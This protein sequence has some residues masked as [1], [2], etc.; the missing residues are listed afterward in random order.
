MSTSAI[1]HLAN[2]SAAW[3]SLDG[4]AVGACESSQQ[5][6]DFLLSLLSGVQAS[7]LALV[8]AKTTETTEIA[9][10]ESHVRIPEVATNGDEESVELEDEDAGEKL[11]TPISF[12]PQLLPELARTGARVSDVGLNSVEDRPAANEDSNIRESGNM[13]AAQFPEQRFELRVLPDSITNSDFASEIASE[14]KSDQ[15]NANATNEPKALENTARAVQSDGEAVQIRETRVRTA[16]PLPLGRELIDPH[17][18]FGPSSIAAEALP[19]EQLPP[20]GVAP[21]NREL[22]PTSESKGPSKDATELQQVETSEQAKVLAQSTSEGTIKNDRSLRFRQAKSGNIPEDWSSRTF[23]SQPGHLE[24]TSRELRT[25]NAEAVQPEARHRAS[26]VHVIPSSHTSAHD[27]KIE[28]RTEMGKVH[29][30]AGISGDDRVDAVIEAEHREVGTL[31]AEHA[32]LLERALADR[33][34]LLGTLSIKD[35]TASFGQDSTDQS[36]S[37]RQTANHLTIPS[38]GLPASTEEQDCSTLEEGR[39]SVRA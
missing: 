11:G 8:E 19:V 17:L 21:R 5:F 37:Q 25:E 29:I 7:A 23:V 36:R 32:P 28:M 27:L 9:K 31:L 24:P 26:E 10:T 20:A 35:G 18:S 16:P 34:I 14:V 2:V 15:T 22:K 33:H 4:T 6:A 1:P 39:L 12:V 13:R 30:R 38:S 3:V